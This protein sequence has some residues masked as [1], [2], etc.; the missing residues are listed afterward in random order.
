[1]KTALYSVH[2][3]SGYIE[4]VIIYNFLVD[5]DSLLHSER[6]KGNLIIFGDEWEGVRTLV[7]GGVWLERVGSGL[8]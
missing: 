7:T 2:G 6:E 8:R 4:I 3:E 5:F 1:M